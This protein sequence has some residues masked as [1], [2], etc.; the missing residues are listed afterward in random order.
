MGQLNVIFEIIFCIFIV[1]MNYFSSE[2]KF[3]CLVVGKNQLHCYQ[4]LH[5]NFFSYIA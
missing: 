4:F 3:I 2:T 5:D 1:E